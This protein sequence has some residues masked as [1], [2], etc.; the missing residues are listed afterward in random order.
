[1]FDIS[2]FADDRN[3]TADLMH[4]RRL[5]YQLSHN[6]CPDLFS[7]SFSI[8]FLG[9]VYSWTIYCPLLLLLQLKAQKTF[10]S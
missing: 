1:M 6:H 3:R 2:F 7:S 5:I 8:L 10:E 4:L 9:I